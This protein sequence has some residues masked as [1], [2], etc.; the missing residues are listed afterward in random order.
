MVMERHHS[1]G[2]L[3]WTPIVFGGEIAAARP[4][5]P[6]CAHK[7]RGHLG[8]TRPSCV[9]AWAIHFLQKVDVEKQ[10][11]RKSLGGDDTPPCFFTE[12][13]GPH[14]TSTRKRFG[15]LP[16]TLEK[17]KRTATL[18]SPTELGSHRCE[19]RALPLIL[20]NEP[21]NQM[22]NTVTREDPG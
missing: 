6:R 1:S 16:F 22:S 20:T 5:R 18:P 3:E 19:C 10:A 17:R 14:G 21:L 9:N 4:H 7:N 13:Y 8:R 12:F 11:F 2:I 15:Q